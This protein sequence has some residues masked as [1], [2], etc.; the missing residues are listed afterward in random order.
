M[1]HPRPGDGGAALYAAQAFHMRWF[2][3][4]RPP[5]GVGVRDVSLERLGFR[6]AGLRARDVLAAAA[7]G[8]DGSNEALRFLDAREV[9][10]LV[11]RQGRTIR[12]RW[13]VSSFASAAKKEV[14]GTPA[15]IVFSTE[16]PARRVSPSKASRSPAASTMNAS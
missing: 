3:A 9:V 11:T 5:R 13:D 12:A 4:H 2:E 6:I 14:A 1:P 8:S 10:Y 15:S 7:P 16:S